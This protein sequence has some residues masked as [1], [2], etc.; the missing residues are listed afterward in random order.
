MANVSAEINLAIQLKG[1][2]GQLNEVE[3]RL[4]ELDDIL[5]KMG[6]DRPEI[7]KKVFSEEDEKAWK[8]N[9]KLANEFLGEAQEINQELVKMGVLTEKGE[10]TK[11]FEETLF[12]D[13]KDREAEEKQ[14][15]K[16]AKKLFGSLQK[17]I[18]GTDL[19]TNS[20]VNNLSKLINKLDR[21]TKALDKADKATKK[22][23]E[24]KIKLDAEESGLRQK[25]R[26]KGQEDINRAME[27]AFR[28]ELAEYVAK[29]KLDAE[30]SGLRQKAQRQHEKKMEGERYD[31]VTVGTGLM[32]DSA[33]AY[34]EEG[35]KSL[36]KFDVGFD[37]IVTDDA[38][39]DI[40]LYNNELKKLDD[41]YERLSEDSKKVIDTDVIRRAKE[42]FQSFNVQAQKSAERIERIIDENSEMVNGK[43]VLL[44]VTEEVKNEFDKEK[45]VLRKATVEMKK[46]KNTISGVTK[47]QNN[48][49]KGQ[50][51]TIEQLEKTSQATIRLAKS[52]K[53]FQL[54]VSQIRNALLLYHF[55]FDP[56]INAIKASTR[57]FLEFE[58]NIE[59][60][61]RV[62]EKMR[63]STTDTKDA[64][65]E[66]TKDGILEVSAAARGMA[67]LLRTGLGLDDATKLMK[68]FKDF[69]AFGR[70]GTMDFSSALETA[71]EGFRNLN[72]RTLDNVGLTTNVDV[73]LARGADRLDKLVSSL[74]DAEKHQ[75]LY[76]E[77]LREGNMVKG[78]AN[79]L[80]ETATGRFTK[81]DTAIERA[82]RSFGAFLDQVGA[83]KLFT[84]VAIR[85][86]ESLENIAW[87]ITKNTL[88]DTE[89]YLAVLQKLDLLSKEREIELRT[90]IALN[91]VATE[92][93]NILK[94][95][96]DIL[97]DINDKKYENMPTQFTDFG[98]ISE[99]MMPWSDTFF[100]P[101][102]GY[103][104]ATL[105]PFIDSIQDRE[106]G[107][108]SVQR[109]VGLESKLIYGLERDFG[110][111]LGKMERGLHELPE[112][113]IGQQEDLQRLK[114]I[115][116]EIGNITSELDS[117]QE[118]ALQYD[119][120]RP[121]FE[122][123]H[124]KQI[125]EE[126]KNLEKLKEGKQMVLRSL[127][128]DLRGTDAGPGPGIMESYMD[129]PEERKKFSR[130]S[131]E[132]ARKQLADN[133]PIFENFKGLAENEVE[134]LNQIIKGEYKNLDLSFPPEII[135]Q[136][137]T[138]PVDPKMLA[139][140]KT[141]DERAV[142]VEEMKS[143]KERLEKFVKFRNDSIRN[144][145][146][147][148]KDRLVKESD[149]LLGSG[150]PWGKNLSDELLMRI[151]E[152]EEVALRFMVDEKSATTVTEQY[153]RLIDFLSGKK[154]AVD[155]AI[156]LTDRQKREIEEM[157][158]ATERFGKGL[159]KWQQQHNT[160][161]AQEQSLR[162]KIRRLKIPEGEREELYKTLTKNL[163]I[164]QK[165]IDAA[166]IHNDE[167]RIT[168]TIIST[169]QMGIKE[170]RQVH[171]KDIDGV[172][173]L[174]G[175]GDDASLLREFE[176]TGL[177]ENL[178]RQ[179]V[180]GRGKLILGE[181]RK[182]RDAR[183]KALDLESTDKEDREGRV[184]GSNLQW[185]VDSNVAARVA[186][187]LEEQQKLHDGLESGA[188]DY[189]QKRKAIADSREEIESKKNKDLIA[190]EIRKGQGYI[191]RETR[192][193]E[194][195]EA[196]EKNHLARKAGIEVQYNTERITQ[197]QKL[198]NTLT[199]IINTGHSEQEKAR[200][201]A[202]TLIKGGMFEQQ[203]GK[204]VE[205]LMARN[206]LETD[207][208]TR[209]SIFDDAGSGGGPVKLKGFDLEE[210]QNLLDHIEAILGVKVTIEQLRQAYERLNIAQE[211]IFSDKYGFFGT[212]GTW[213]NLT[214]SISKVE[215]TLNNASRAAD[216][217]HKHGMDAAEGV[218]EKLEL[219][220][221]AARDA[222]IM[223]GQ[224][225]AL[226]G[227]QGL[228]MVNPAIGAVVA[229]I[230]I[231]SSV[232]AMFNEAEDK[233]KKR[234]A[235][236]DTAF[237]ATISRGPEVVNITP[238][239]TVNSEHDT[240]FSEDGLGVV[241]D[242]MLLMMQQA[243]D[244]G[245]LDLTNVS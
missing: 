211:K 130:M 79:K 181:I 120:I 154:V 13:K 19:A 169:L 89:K 200:K 150:L 111:M 109:W 138:L 119:L 47:E 197:E 193:K 37:E 156:V 192:V 42:G 162:D 129:I 103:I 48:W 58:R 80:T 137:T 177:N 113:E 97:K 28:K 67:E 136:L 125:A 86:A 106:M 212:K 243:I 38:I 182:V 76:T 40:K 57:A 143:Q 114:N 172:Q 26:R 95:R 123:A 207:K 126:I 141:E 199:K 64:I 52:M 17:F 240:I 8:H 65:E 203:D 11:G 233:E 151:P 165:E 158:A 83:L 27:A 149:K 231:I 183:I 164:K 188:T 118:A 190:A 31:K 222:Q 77:I 96:A 81:M 20:H 84:D 128:P 23:A 152:L 98:S 12:K 180:E 36:R 208:K 4:K 15:M 50:T 179:Q 69:A 72:S 230:G 32:Q 201:K 159:T 241:H 107:R 82:A 189:E 55:A 71:A 185:F 204:S 227:A 160:L 187:Q 115:S 90:N 7:M 91:K 33:Q 147:I 178:F 235:K 163:E 198:Q 223:M 234:K 68:T 75:I 186:S 202:I 92:S 219:V 104:K 59:G 53:G 39:R 74:S 205:E 110:L 51:K 124:R 131:I 168:K 135:E 24:D 60:V 213:T 221:N 242:N 175:I 1:S 62:A 229:G 34:R 140:G 87:N 3:K 99:G 117:L 206:K 22:I 61:T 167:L 5:G 196:L 63:I 45:S 78:D 108:A 73:L 66:L 215:D 101:D 237:G 148:E 194:G 133:F 105:A 161:L 122:N 94:K 54:T 157:T 18:K 2:V 217:F 139:E 121:S 153:E 49:A 245:E 14:Q 144:M 93:N 209:M 56:I 238:V 102:P 184:G 6:D 85:L 225:Q 43:R 88:T 220:A 224:I 214:D 228:A 44:K 166:K 21:T 226:Q 236:Q 70:K 216:L 35:R 239:L 46:H 41:K 112:L 195:L 116:N 170:R 218:A 176:E 145:L 146:E 134:I 100:G 9:I 191:D 25:A 244:N 132:D 127:V 232:Y 29:V 174:Y 142:L 173:T 155:P 171:T 10:W 210:T 30:E 16:D